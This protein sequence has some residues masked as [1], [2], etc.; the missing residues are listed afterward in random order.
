MKDATQSICFF[1]FAILN[2][3]WFDKTGFPVKKKKKGQKSQL[4]LVLTTLDFGSALFV[5]ATQLCCAHSM[6]VLFHVAK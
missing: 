3:K 5:T 6:S 4:Y 1:S 2:L